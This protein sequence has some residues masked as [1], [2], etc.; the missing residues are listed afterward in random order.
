M[1]ALLATIGGV[2]PDIDH[3]LGVEIKTLT[4]LLGT[5]GALFAWRKLAISGVEWPVELEIWTI[6]GVYFLLRIGLRSFLTRFMVHR[7][8]SHSVPTGLVW[9]ALTYLAYPSEH[10]I[11]RVWMSGAVMLGFLSHLTLDEVCS[12]DLK[13]HRVKR[14]FGTAIKFWA[15]SLVSTLA[16]YTI[17]Y[18]LAQAVVNEW[19][20]TQLMESLTQRVPEPNLPQLPK[21][22]RLPTEWIARPTRGAERA[23]SLSVPASIP[24]PTPR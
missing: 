3:P 24:A 7:G 12:V 1:A 5:A 8:M 6:L 20:R 19:P 22:W 14:S 11:V 9:G 4:T 21:S 13:G 17:L 16:V 10:H 15:P 2:L 18:F 23:G